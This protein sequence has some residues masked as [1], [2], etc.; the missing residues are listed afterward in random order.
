MDYARGVGNE[1]LAKSILSQISIERVQIK[2]KDVKSI[3]VLWSLSPFGKSLRV[4]S[5][6]LILNSV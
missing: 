2:A 4:S 3:T 6:V 5:A 1:E